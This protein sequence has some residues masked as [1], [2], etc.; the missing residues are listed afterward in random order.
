LK[1][2]PTPTRSEEPSPPINDHITGIASGLQASLQAMLGG[3]PS[4][5]VQ[6]AQ[7]QDRYRLNRV[8]CQ[9]LSTALRR[10]N[11]LSTLHQIPGP[12]P[13]RR[14]IEAAR[15]ANVSAKLVNSAAEAIDDFE[16]LIRTVGGDR[17][18]LDAIICAALPEARG[19]YESESKQLVYRGM[20]QIQGMA[21][22]VVLGA[23]FFHPSD[24]PLYCDTVAIRGYFGIRRIRPSA[25]LQL[26][27]SGGSSVPGTEALTLDGRPLSKH[28]ESAILSDFC[29]VPPEDIAIYE[30]GTKTI[31]SLNWGD[32]V[33]LPSARDLVIVERRAHCARRQKE[34]GE[35]C[36][37]GYITNE[38]DVPARIYIN[39]VILHEDIHPDWDMD[40]RVLK[41][42]E[43][44]AANANDPVRDLDVIDIEE[45]T[46]FLGND[47]RKFPVDDIPNYVGL[48]EH[49]FASIGWDPAQFR[50]YRTRI[51]YPI[52]SSQVQHRFR[53]A[54][55]KDHS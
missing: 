44:G 53:L 34:S 48:L 13:L 17:S 14:L 51:H 11:P 21:A 16:N 36:T 54:V 15:S 49:V 55:R 42:G 8:F 23:F 25:G 37:Y 22:D 29:T 4:A 35:D 18:G 20:R 39:D 9:K 19:R 12:E 6:R 10:P 1:L 30:L 45:S 40:M 33:G 26:K 24:N 7:I 52:F 3:T 2:E 46:E 43:Q 31:Y 50:G 38:I 28:P 32:E 41:T 27:I 47:Y 5:P